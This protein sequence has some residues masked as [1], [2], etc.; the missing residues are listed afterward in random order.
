MPRSFWLKKGYAFFLRTCCHSLGSVPFLGQ[1]RQGT[2]PWL[3]A[4][5]N[6]RAT[7]LSLLHFIS[8]QGFPILVEPAS[9]I[10]PVEPHSLSI[11]RFYLLKDCQYNTINSQSISKYMRILHLSLTNFRNYA[12]LELDFPPGVVLLQGDNAQGKTNLLEAIYYLSRMHSPRTSVDRELVN[13]LAWK[14][15]LPFARLVAQIQSDEQTDQIELSLVQ[16]STGNVDVNAVGVRKHIRVNG[17][18]KRALDVIGLLHVVLFL[19]QDINLVDGPP[20]LRRQYLDDT[21]SQ[22]DAQYCRELQHYHRVLTQRNYLLKSLKGRGYDEAQLL[23]WDQRLVQHGAYLIVRR[24]QVIQQL[25]E[26]VQR[27][28]PQ[29][30]GETERLRLEY[31]ASVQLER[32]PGT[33]YQMALPTEPGTDTASASTRLQDVAAL[34]ADQ[35]RAIRVKEQEQGISLVGPHRDNLRFL[36]NGVDMNVYGS[37]GQQRTIAL[38]LKLAEVEW[39]AQERKDK[40]VLLLDDVL[41]E[42]DAAHRRYLLDAIDQAQ[43]VIITTTDFTPFNEEF[44]SRATLWRV[45]AGRIT[46]SMTNS[47]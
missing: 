13:W 35:L 32:R 41:S 3:N 29:L 34:F 38:S 46:T 24:Q 31:D 45:C 40:P 27:I 14:E 17:V 12:R 42:L 18:P 39:T 20:H 11:Y 30:T 44:L 33:A 8:S 26:F 19:P 15:D 4:G 10:C 5:K 22:V 28:H 43:Q 25:D 6:V 1:C 21:I 23:F 7:N 37:R 9:P 16:N 36:V 2:I 47:Q